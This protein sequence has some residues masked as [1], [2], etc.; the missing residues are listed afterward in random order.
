[1]L[2]KLEVIGLY[3]EKG[4]AYTMLTYLNQIITITTI[5]II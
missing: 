2:S 1:M 5:V 3:C 4:D